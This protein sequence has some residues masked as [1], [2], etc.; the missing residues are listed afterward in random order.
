MKPL[1]VLVAT[2][3][4]LMT[5][6]GASA[7]AAAGSTVVSA[8]TPATSPDSPTPSG[9]PS[10]AAAPSTSTLRPVPFTREAASAAPRTS[11]P[12]SSPAVCGGKGSAGTHADTVVLKADFY[13]AGD[14]NDESFSAQMIVS[15]TD[16]AGDIPGIQNV[17]VQSVGCGTAVV[18]FGA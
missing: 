14:A 2:A 10:T 12:G 18:H 9:S 4:S 6:L 5:L 7:A 8:S 17:W 3:V 16:I 15:A 13:Q 1:H 11:T